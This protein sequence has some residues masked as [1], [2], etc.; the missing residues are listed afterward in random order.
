MNT[1]PRILP[2][3]YQQLSLIYG[4]HLSI[5]P[6]RLLEILEL[7]ERIYSSLGIGEY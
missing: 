3:P 4:T 7:G 2:I 6:G 5:T 1:S